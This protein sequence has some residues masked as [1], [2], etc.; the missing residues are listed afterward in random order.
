MNGAATRHEDL[1][2]NLFATHNRGPEDVWMAISLSDG[3]ILG[4]RACSSR[5]EAM[6]AAGA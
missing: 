2:R 1:V 6:E 3:R 4:W 5:D